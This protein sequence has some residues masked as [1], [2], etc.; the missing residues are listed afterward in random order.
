VTATSCNL[1]TC[2]L[3]TIPN[4]SAK[5]C[6]HCRSSLG[7]RRTVHAVSYEVISGGNDP[8]GSTISR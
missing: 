4:Q 1:V 7:L 3:D 2:R 6:Q 5:H 8:Q